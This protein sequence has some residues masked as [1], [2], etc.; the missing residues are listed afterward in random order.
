MTS[1][2][3]SWGALPPVR[4]RALIKGASSTVTVAPQGGPRTNQT[5]GW[6]LGVLLENAGLPS[7]VRNVG[8]AAQKVTQAMC[9]W[10]REIKQWSP[11]VVVL[12]YGEYECMPALLPRWLERHA[13][14]WHHHAGSLRNRYRTKILEPLWRRLASYQG[15][16]DGLLDPGPFRTSPR[17][18]VEELSRLVEMTRAVSGPLI[19]VMDTWPLGT[20][21]RKWFPGMDQ[22]VVEMRKEIVSW[23]TTNEDPEVRLFRLSEIVG[24]RPVDEALPDGVHFSAALHRE[25]AEELAKEILAWAAGQP[26]LQRSGMGSGCFER[27][28]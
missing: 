25:I 20:R 9:D 5:Y 1:E 11:D 14:G 18:T 3:A 8:I 28:Q 24:R 27:V 26:H 7:D 2:R 17:R 12:N 16:I 21:W 13:T 22:R 4:L 10:E 19:L 15:F 23:L 6:W